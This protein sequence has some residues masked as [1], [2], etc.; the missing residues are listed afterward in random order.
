MK[1]NKISAHQRLEVL[2]A[3]IAPAGIASADFLPASVGG[4]NLV[5]A[6][7]G[8]GTAGN[9]SGTYLLYVEKGSAI[10]FNTD[11][12]HNG[13]VDSNEI[14]GI[15]A[16]D[17]LRLIS[18]VD[19]HGDI[20]TNLDADSTLSDSDNNSANNSDLGNLQGDGRVVNNTR[21]EKIELRSLT[22]ADLVDQNS[23]GN[24]DDTD[25]ELRLAMSS[26]SIFGN[27]YAGK[28]FGIPGGVGSGL[29]IDD[30]GKEIQSS[31][32]DGRGVDF[33]IDTKPS[34]DWIKTGTASSFEHF[35]FGASENV[36]V[37]G[38]L[39]AFT[40]P[41]GQA[42]GDIAGVKTAST[43]QLATNPA[44]SDTTK[45]NIAGLQSGKGGT[46]A[47]GGNIQDVILDGDTAGGYSMI[48]GDGG[49]GPNGGA[50][51]S[52]LN[53]QDLSSITGTVLLQSGT[54]GKATAGAGGNAG[55]LTLGI[56]NVNASLTIAPGSGGDGFIRGGDGAG[57]TK[58]SIV[59]PDPTTVDSALTIVGTTRDVGHD[60]ATGKLFNTLGDP[61]L[62]DPTTNLPYTKGVIGR[63]R[64]IDFN[65]DGFGDIVYSTDSPDQLVVALGDQFG[66]FIAAPIYLDSP[67]DPDAVTVGDFNADGFMDVAAASH[68]PGNMDGIVVYLAK[69][70]DLNSDGK[71]S[72][73]ED[74]NGNG[75]IDFVGFRSG[76][77]SVMPSLYSGENT[78]FGFYRSP[79]KISSITAG[80]F[81]GDGFTDLAAAATLTGPGGAFQAVVFFISDQEKVPGTGTPGIPGSELVRP[82]GQFYADFGSK[83][84]AQPPVPSKPYR[85]FITLAAVDAPTVIEAS[86]FSA[87][88]DHDIVFAGIQ[89]G[90]SV[91]IIDNYPGA[92]VQAGGPRQGN[93]SGPVS[94]TTPLGTVDT[95]RLL[96]IQNIGRVGATFR[97]LTLLDSNNDGFTDL[98]VGIN[99][100]TSEDTPR[101]LLVAKLGNGVTF[102]TFLT[103]TNIDNAGFAV[104]GD[105]AHVRGVDFDNDGRVDNVAVYQRV[106]LPGNVFAFNAI[107]LNL[108]DVAPT[109][110]VLNPGGALLTTQRSNAASVGF[111]SALAL[112]DGYAFDPYIAQLPTLP[113]PAA[114]TYIPAD[115][116]YV[117]A[118]PQEFIVTEP[119]T[120]VIDLAPHSFAMT[121]GDGGN[122]LLGR[123]GMGGSLGGGKLTLDN[124]TGAVTAAIS[125][126]LP[127]GTINGTSDFNLVGGN[128]G[129]GFTAGGKGGGIS[130]TSIRY[131]PAPNGLT[132]NTSIFFTG[133]N[134][135]FGVTGAGGAGGNLAANSI[136]NGVEFIGG[137]GGRGIVGGAGGSVTGN[138]IKT[139]AGQLFDTRFPLTT[140]EGGVGGNG[141]KRGGN[142]GIIKD[143]A[144]EFTVNTL[145]SATGFLI[146]R[147]GDAGNATA[148]AGGTGG[149][150]LNASP[151]VGTNV[152]GGDIFL[153]GGAG[154]NGTSGGSGGSVSGFT[155]LPS[156]A[157]NPAILTIIGGEGGSGVG[158]VG[159]HGGDV[160]SINV[161]G[162]KGT[163]NPIAGSSTLFTFNR[164]L[165]GN[166]GV[167]SGGLGGEGG[168]ISKVIAA[169]SDN[170]FLVAAGAGGAGLRKGGNGGD[171]KDSS[172]EV[173]GTA[174]AKLLVVAGNGGDASSF[175]ANPLD[176]VSNQG[177]KAY[178]GKVGVGGKG[179]SIVNFTQGKVTNGL[180]GGNIQARVDLIAGNGGSTINYGTVADTEITVGVGGSISKI[181]I[182]GS[183]GNSAANVPIKSYNNDLGGETMAD[184]IN[185]N[186]RDEPAGF[187]PSIADNVGNV[188]VVAGAAG[189]LKTVVIGNDD[190]SIVYRSQPA[191]NGVNGS[192]LDLAARDIMSI[193]AGSVQR[194]ASIQKLGGI[195]VV[196][197]GDVGSDKGIVG[198]AEYGRVPVLGVLVTP[199][200]IEPVLDGSLIDGAV[201]YRKPSGAIPTGNVFNLA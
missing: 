169:N 164:I 94:S 102:P 92:A 29:L 172:I 90:T 71:L 9:N 75:Q 46:A 180:L 19:I 42:G 55:A 174:L 125:I 159:G 16:S 139:L 81:N 109:G 136:V 30:A 201:I 77:H 99:E 149:S 111:G 35:S 44:P 97:D 56:F 131:A 122:A 20:V 163:V 1:R 132:I 5:N 105:N 146:Y 57:L 83:A 76:I 107:G 73:S 18:F 116:S 113:T 13:A 173:G 40:P 142:G 106:T 58:A 48:A 41:A 147:G 115:Y 140:V 191:K 168:T 153:S 129:S 22:A 69:T 175:V 91:S 82:T 2:E 12:N 150:V 171:V 178:G 167:S 189:R 134:G 37:Q 192:V 157:D 64:G 50:G 60:P 184:F 74:V 72:V 15:A 177:Q 133:G 17:G 181:R 33:F 52:I 68:D 151:V 70:E 104:G 155:N 158:G 80:D 67:V 195:K 127:V 31:F 162:T 120:P 199:I 121:G 103:N 179:G 118:L 25:V 88:S 43:S 165:A 87:T 176:Q 117:G 114:P 154:G 39:T 130:G 119:P 144:A 7:Q 145:G 160:T 66:R 86:A 93:V 197:T 62:L 135:G 161:P 10:V 47:R 27:V 84:S 194:I 182:A 26:Y 148:G 156:T 54:G 38:Y 138:G 89:G 79:A 21:I 6:G 128:G 152:L 108:D 123:G 78:V 198:I 14:T 24:V 45:F 100:L 95:N 166:G 32:F 49:D 98:V 196:G 190:N 187:V 65:H 124:A 188:G 23:D 183:L 185:T 63:S 137:D 143:F 53:L 85:P 8:L 193:I 101:G 34:I 186:L 11:F 112:G 28:G 59:I 110:I 61:T 96:G 126:T 170:P 51:G 36:N 200:G 3:R 4:F 141:V